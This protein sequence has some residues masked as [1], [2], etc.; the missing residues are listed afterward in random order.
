MKKE[1][2]QKT[3]EHIRDNKTMAKMRAIAYAPVKIKDT[4]DTSLGT[5]GILLLEAEAKRLR[6]QMRNIKNVQKQTS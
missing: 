4:K 5:Q 3:Q 1:A 2:L 6:K